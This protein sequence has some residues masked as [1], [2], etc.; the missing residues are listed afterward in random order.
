MQCTL[1][2][3]SQ[4]YGKWL[5][6]GRGYK[7]SFTPFCAASA[8]K[9]RQSRRTPRGTKLEGRRFK[10]YPRNQLNLLNTGVAVE[11]QQEGPG[12]AIRDRHDDG[13]PLGERLDKAPSA[14]PSFDLVMDQGIA[15]GACRSAAFGTVGGSASSELRSGPRGTCCSLV[16][17]TS[18]SVRGHDSRCVPVAFHGRNPHRGLF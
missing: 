3:I 18:C 7:A 16:Q 13:R 2:A 5:R 1:M 10:F 11:F 8:R 4:L 9:L 6:Q 12:E 17:S 14:G 15:F